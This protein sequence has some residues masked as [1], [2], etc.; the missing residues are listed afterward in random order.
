MALASRFALMVERCRMVADIL[1]PINT[2][3]ASRR[4]SHGREARGQRPHR[5]FIGREGCGSS[6]GGE[7]DIGGADTALDSR[8]RLSKA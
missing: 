3:A 2:T 7:K 1:A 6:L 5:F 4:L 8:K